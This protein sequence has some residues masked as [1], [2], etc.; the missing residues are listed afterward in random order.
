MEWERER[1]EKF[2][3][4]VECVGSLKLDPMTLDSGQ[5]RWVLKTY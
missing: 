2:K 1:R 4:V 5:V 3:F